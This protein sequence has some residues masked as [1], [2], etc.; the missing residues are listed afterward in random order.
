[1]RPA[2]T[3]PRATVTFMLTDIE[4]STHLLQRLGPL[5]RD[6]LAEHH[7]LLLEQVEAASGI[8]VSA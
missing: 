2:P 7:R 5:H 8:R 1:M 4:G 3:L 6:L